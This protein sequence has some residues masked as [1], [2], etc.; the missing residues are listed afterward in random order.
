MSYE[1]IKILDTLGI[2]ENNRDKVVQKMF[3]HDA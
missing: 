1:Y 3:S 2:Y